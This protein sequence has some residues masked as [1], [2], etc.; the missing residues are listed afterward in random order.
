MKLQKLCTVLSLAAVFGLTACGDDDSSPTGSNSGKGGSSTGADVGKCDFTLDDDE[1]EYSYTSTYSSGEYA[2]TIISFNSGTKYTQKVISYSND[3]ASKEACK[4][5]EGVGDEYEG[6]QAEISCEGGVMHTTATIQGDYQEDYGYESKEEFFEATMNTCK[7]LNNITDKSSS[8]KG[9]KDE[10][11][12]K[13]SS[14]RITDDDPYTDIDEDDYTCSTEGAK[15]T[16]EGVA[17]VCY[18]GYWIPEEYLSYFEDDDGTGDDDDGWEDDDDWDIELTEDMI[19]FVEV[20]ESDYY[21]C[22]EEEEGETKTLSNG[23]ASVCMDEVW[24]PQDM[25]SKFLNKSCTEGAKDTY[26]FKLQNGSYATLKM[27]CDEGEW[28]LDDV[29][30]P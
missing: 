5:L 23:V 26:K 25:V 12:E 9:G 19:A 6:L 8:S 29:T 16:I 28:V 21:A 22:D 27:V 20:I 30:M 3:K 7:N 13:S 11:N 4:A 14:S 15:K 18:Q 1:W 17:A 24:T 2:T 10:G